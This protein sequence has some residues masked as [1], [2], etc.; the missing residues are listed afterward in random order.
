MDDL[1]ENPL[2]LEIP[3]FFALCTNNHIWCQLPRI[4]SGASSTHDVSCVQGFECKAGPIGISAVPSPGFLGK[5]GEWSK[6][7]P[8]AKLR[9]VHLNGFRFLI[10]NIYIYI[11]EP[12][13]EFSGDMLVRKFRGVVLVGCFFT[14]LGTNISPTKRCF[15]RRWFSFSRFV[16]YVNFLECNIRWWNIG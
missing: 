16:G 11:S 4:V 8:H 3:I 1:G 6:Y 12:T 14:L 15:W 10:G 13:I 7:T 5:R 2:F 9:N